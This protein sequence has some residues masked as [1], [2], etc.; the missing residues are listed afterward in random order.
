MTDAV[1]GEQPPPAPTGDWIADLV[2]IGEG[3]RSVL[4]RHPWLPRLVLTRP[5]VGPNGL[6]VLEHYLSVLEAHPAGTGAKMEAFAMLNSLAA[7]SV[8]YELAGGSALQER[9]V[10]YLRHALESGERPGLARL[11]SQA[12]PAS[13]AVPD[14]AD[15]YPDVLA[16]VLT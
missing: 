6:A 3:F 1:G 5:V 15:R 13:E 2:A 14:P 7:T 16:R 11:L 8:Q 10:A 9:N 12:P 4:R